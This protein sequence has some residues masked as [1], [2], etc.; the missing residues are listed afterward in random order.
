MLITYLIKNRERLDLI[1]KYGIKSILKRW[2]GAFRLLRL[3]FRELRFLVA[4]SKIGNL[5]VI[6]K[7]K[8][9]G[10]KSRF[11][12]GRGGFIGKGVFVAL[13]DK[14]SIGNHVVINSDVKLF[15]ASHNVNSPNWETVKS[16]IIIEDYVWIASGAIILPGSKLCRGSVV[17]AG[18]VVTGIVEEGD[19][20]AGNPAK[21][22]KNRGVKSYCYSP[23]RQSAV[24]QAWLGSE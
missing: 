15:T 13:H 2:A 18:A 12:I 1:S 23:A 6:E 11:E 9:E 16:S 7:I 10:D 8:V 4:G 22:I 21:K 5:V 19:V 3:S 17:G 14:V 24:V 20:V